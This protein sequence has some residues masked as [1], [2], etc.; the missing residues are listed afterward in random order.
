MTH[1]TAINGSPRKHGNTDAVLDAFLLGS[2]S[3]GATTSKISLG[4]IDHKNC[5]GC[6]ACHKKGVCILRDDLTPVFDEVLASD[7]LV[8]ASPIY[9]MTITAE[10]KSLIDR[11]Q[12]LWAQKYITKTLTFP[13]E[14]LAKHIGVYLGTSGQNIPHIFDAAFPVVRALFN[15]TG[16]SYTENVLFPGMDQY[17]GVKGWPESVAA[18][19]TEGKRIAS[20]ICHAGY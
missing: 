12:F 15:D 3:T 5:R 17:G 7:I 13:K 2:K 6:N 11:G 1:I 9:S 8:L 20:L 4:D 16:F 18:A 14:H 19:K 10:M